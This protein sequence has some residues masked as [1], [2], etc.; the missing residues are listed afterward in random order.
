MWDMNEV[1]RL[2]YQGAYTYYI[3]FDDGTSGDIDFTDYLRR[4]PIFA[5]LAEEGQFEQARIEGGTI[6][7]PNGADIAPETLYELLERR[8]RGGESARAEG[9]DEHESGRPRRAHG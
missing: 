8:N 4:G 9:A 3:E 1:T 2:E 5:A 7:W 6:A